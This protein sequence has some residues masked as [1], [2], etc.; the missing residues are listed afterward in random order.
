MCC[1]AGHA[2]YTEV[3]TKGVVED[4]PADPGGGTEPDKGNGNSVAGSRG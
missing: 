3:I 2:S 4:T 1:Y